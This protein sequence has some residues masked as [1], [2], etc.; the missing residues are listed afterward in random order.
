VNGVSLPKQYG[1]WSLQIHH[2]EFDPETGDPTSGVI[3]YEAVVDDGVTFS[4]YI[5]NDGDE[6]GGALLD[7][8]QP[9]NPHRNA[10][11]TFYGEDIPAILTE[12][13]HVMNRNIDDYIR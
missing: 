4:V 10:I 1:L 12:A 13:K 6:W 2:I 7:T 8:G 5:E 9:E 3:Q 11:S